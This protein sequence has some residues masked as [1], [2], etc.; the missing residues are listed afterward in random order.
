M[1]PS[2]REGIEALAVGEQPAGGEEKEEEQSGDL[3]A[4]DVKMV[5]ATGEE[6]TSPMEEEKTNNGA[7]RS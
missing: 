7:V 1:E 6:T 5:E 3:G 2:L 4:N